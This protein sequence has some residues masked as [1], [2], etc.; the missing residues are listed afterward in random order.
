MESSEKTIK[1]LQD[2][3]KSLQKEVLELKLALVKLQS[4]IKRLMYP[5]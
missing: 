2:Q 1:L 5:G 4:Q 3:I